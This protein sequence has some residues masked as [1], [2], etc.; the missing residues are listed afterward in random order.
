MTSRPFVPTPIASRADDRRS[1]VGVVAGDATC[2]AEVDS[3]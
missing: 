1:V 3:R 2:M